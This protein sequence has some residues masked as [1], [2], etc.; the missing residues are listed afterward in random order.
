[1]P[2]PTQFDSKTE[3]PNT[4][5]GE[6]SNYFFA[7]IL[8]FIFGIFGIPQLYLKGWKSGLTRLVVN[9][10]LIVGAIILAQV[11][12]LPAMLSYL[13][14]AI[15][16]YPIIESVL[17][18]IYED[19]NASKK[20][21]KGKLKL[22]KRYTGK[23]KA[24]IALASLSV[25]LY[26][27]AALT[28]P[29]PT[30]VSTA[31]VSGQ[32]ATVQATNAPSQTDSETPSTTSLANTNVTIKFI[33]VGQG[34]AILI[35]LPEKTMLI[36]AGPTGSA[37]KIA[38]VLHELGREKIDYLVATHP[39][40]DHIGGMADV[41]SSTQIG[42]I[43]APNKTNNTATYRKFLTAIQNNNLQI[44]LAEAGAIIDQ[45]NDYKIEILWPTK[46]A[47]FPDTNDYSIIIKLTVGNKT[48]LF[49][50]DAPTSAILQSNPGHIDVLKLSHHGS[51][52]GTN[53]QLVRKLSPTY[54]VISY[55]LDNSY[56]HPMQSVLNALHKHSV[57]I[58]G[59][60]ANGTIT[61][62]CDGTTIDISGE[63]N[64]TVVAPTSQEKPGTSS[65]SRTK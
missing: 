1:M 41:I 63:K 55:A 2:N 44:T 36:D 60:G 6:Q 10:V 20:L 21:I 64:G 37:P 15:L 28:Q 12:A 29:L 42:T 40:E 5:S 39:D 4:A 61:I 45:T 26:F 50:G 24:G 65:T 13:L 47:N 33:D 3:S 35:A 18:L 16:S 51:R 14:P 49:T 54:A 59:T 17:N 19:A 48:F 9:V 46:D 57:E 53:E 56:G 30:T 38:Q 8:S 62:T 32:Q 23:Q 11:F 31:S 22:H 52:T 7:L 34:E 58:W 25:A 27:S 43:Y